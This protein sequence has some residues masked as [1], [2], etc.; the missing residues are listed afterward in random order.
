LSTAEAERL[1][2]ESFYMKEPYWASVV[3]PEGPATGEPGLCR[4][5]FELQHLRD[6]GLVECVESAAGSAAARTARFQ[7][8]EKG[9]A[10]AAA[11]WLPEWPPRDD[12][13]E[14]WRVPLAVKTFDSVV[15][16]EQEGRSATVEFA[17]QWSST[18]YNGDYLLFERVAPECLPCSAVLH[19]VDGRWVLDEWASEL[20]ADGYELLNARPASATHSDL[21]VAVH[22]ESRQIRVRGAYAAALPNV[23]GGRMHG[24]EYT[25]EPDDSQFGW[26]WIRVR[27]ASTSGYFLFLRWHPGGDRANEW[28]AVREGATPEARNDVCVFGWQ[29]GKRGFDVDG[30]AQDSGRPVLCEPGW[31]ELALAHVNEIRALVKNAP[32]LVP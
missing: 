29:R 24:F 2:R 10:E 9:R 19:H 23:G 13:W 27:G 31:R 14:T 12:G 3:L 28:I 11:S 21:L 32:P 16:V 20:A 5:H 7:L 1:V 6:E 15:S 17:W 4:Q 8:T 30:F 26:E 25:A 18:P 22:A